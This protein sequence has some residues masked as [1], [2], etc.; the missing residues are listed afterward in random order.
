MQCIVQD[1]KG[2]AIF[3]VWFNYRYIDRRIEE[4]KEFLISGKLQYSFGRR[5][6]VH[7]ELDE[8]EDSLHLNRITPFYSLTEG[9][10]HK[11]IREWVNTAI[12]S[13]KI[14]EDPLPSYIR[15]ER[16]LMDIKHAIKE[17]HFPYNEHYLKMA[18]YRFVFE[19]FLP[20]SVGTVSRWKLMKT[21]KGKNRNYDN[22]DVADKYL[23][24]LPFELTISQKKVINEIEKDLRS[25][26]PMNRLLQGDVGSGKT[27][28]AVWSMLRVVSSGY[29]SVIMAPTEILATQHYFNIKEYMDK[30]NI[31]VDLL[32]GSLT[33]KEKQTVKERIKKGET[34]IVIGTHAL[35]Q[36]DVEFNNLALVIIDEQ[37]RFGVKQRLQLR[38][39]GNNADLLVM[40]ATPIPRSLQMTVYGDLDI[41]IIDE[42]PPGRKPI[43]TELFFEK[44]IQI[45]YERIKE[46]VKRGEGVYFV[47]PLIEESE[48]DMMKHIKSIYKTEEELK[49]GV[50]GISI[51]VLHGKMK[52]D[53][54]NSIMMKFKNKEIDLLL[55]TTV[56]EVGVD[57]PHATM[58]IIRHAERFGIAQLHQLRGRVGRNDLQ[59]YCI[60]ISSNNVSE[61]SLHRLNL[62]VKYSSGFDLA[63]EDLKIRGPGEIWGTRQHGM[64]M[65]KIA[66]IYKDRHILEDTI[67][68]AKRIVETDPQLLLSD[69]AILRK[70]Y[71]DVI[72]RSVVYGDS[73]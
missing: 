27:V 52:K 42:M 29:Q 44:D 71:F 65:F 1:E 13:L 32:I 54:K 11:N 23:S 12:K 10:T 41:S 43:K 14:W 3:L 37:H 70:Y 26:M 22:S 56:I 21:V 19:E 53:E 48:S 36:E 47:V 8:V 28:V 16:N 63:E 51:G 72:K 55:S 38:K 20:I 2:N 7:P 35:F 31:S 25:S 69:H 61:E 73:G 40:T 68:C 18:R 64:P 60:L 33:N 67:E 24:M 59:S 62:M 4:G 34:D 57:V 50:E 49:K 5:Q 39:K 46:T 30:L 66:S 45:I 15:R 9:I 58:I 17:I 6:M